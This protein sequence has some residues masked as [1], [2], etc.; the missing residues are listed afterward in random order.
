MANKACLHTVNT[1]LCLQCNTNKPFGGKP[2]ISVGDFHQVAPIVR[3]SGLGA[4]ID[5]SIQTLGLQLS[6]ALSKLKQLMQNATNLDYC[7][8][9]NN[10]SEDVEC[11]C[12]I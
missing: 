3:G 12:T 2:F 4:T 5:A 9:V 10:I 11:S 8:Y 7:N 1:L 6:F